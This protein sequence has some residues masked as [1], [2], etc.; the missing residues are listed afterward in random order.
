MPTQHRTN[1]KPNK[2]FKGRHATKSA[3]KEKAK[4]R[5]PGS[6][7]TTSSSRSK[8]SHQQSAAESKVARRNTTKQLQAAKRASLVGQQRL[9]QGR[10]GVPRVV[11]VVELGEGLDGRR[12]VRELCAALGEEEVD[13][14][15]PVVKVECVSPLS[16]LCS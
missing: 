9:Y 3:L 12:C 2:P 11:C 8:S 10:N 13:V 6:G 16:F 14:D 5:L 15:Q 7:P 4:G 1:V